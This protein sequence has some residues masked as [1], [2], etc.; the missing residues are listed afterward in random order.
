MSPLGCSIPKTRVTPVFFCGLTG[1]S[2]LGGAILREIVADQPDG[3]SRG[4][5]REIRAEEGSAKSQSE[6]QELGMK[7]QRADKPAD[8]GEVHGLTVTLLHKPAESPKQDH[9]LGQE[10]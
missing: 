2:K 8:D 7:L 3:K 9:C 4:V 5:E 1:V 10:C 6:G